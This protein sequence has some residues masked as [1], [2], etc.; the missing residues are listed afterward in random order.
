MPT[1]GFL[2]STVAN[3]ADSPKPPTKASGPSGGRQKKHSRT[4][5]KPPANSRDH[6]DIYIE[7]KRGERYADA[8]RRVGGIVVE[9][10]LVTG[11][12][13]LRTAYLGVVPGDTRSSCYIFICGGD[14]CSV[15]DVGLSVFIEIWKIQPG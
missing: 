9:A 2:A 4:W 13:K 10:A 11:N 1:L 5:H 7:S 8:S 6:A 14:V 12:G 3:R 15:G